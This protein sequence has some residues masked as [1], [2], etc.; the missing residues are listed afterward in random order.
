QKAMVAADRSGIEA[1]VIEFES[2][3]AV[4]TAHEGGDE[5]SVLGDETVAARANEA[6]FR[7]LRREGVERL[8]QIHNETMQAVGAVARHRRDFGD[9][10]KTQLVLGESE[11]RPQ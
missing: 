3:R 6:L 4:E 11:V 7:T 1:G 9:V 2:A 8:V 10:R 5:R